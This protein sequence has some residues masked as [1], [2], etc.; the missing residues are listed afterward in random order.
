MSQN[1]AEGLL[2]EIVRV[3][4]LEQLY[5][6]LDGNAGFVAAMLMRIQLNLAKAA[7]G[8]RDVVA[9]LHCYQELKEWKE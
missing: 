4:R 6:G 1:L 8:R 3:E 9:M 2:D 7:A 5:C